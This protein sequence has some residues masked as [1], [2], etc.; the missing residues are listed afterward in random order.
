MFAFFYNS[1]LP[2]TTK[3]GKIHGDIEVGDLGGW[4]IRTH[5]PPSFICQRYSHF[6]TRKKANQDIFIKK[7][8]FSIET[9]L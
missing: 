5:L 1:D 2:S 7:K 3:H 9:M 8:Q 4:E 6:C